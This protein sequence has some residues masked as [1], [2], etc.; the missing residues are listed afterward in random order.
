MDLPG[1]QYQQLPGKRLLPLSP[2][3]KGANER[4]VGFDLTTGGTSTAT[5]T[6]GG[7]AIIDA[8]VTNTPIFIRT[9]QPSNGRL[10][11]SIVINNA[12]LTN[13]PVA[14]GVA[15]GAVVL[16]GGTTTIQ[17]WGQGNVFTGTNPNG[18]FVQSNIV[19]AN[20]PA[21]LLDGSGKIFGKSHPQYQA[22][23][24]SQIV[25]VKD[26]GARGDG[27]T[28]DT[29]ALKAIFAK[30]S[31][32][33]LLTSHQ[34]SML[35]DTNSLL[36]VKSSF[37]TQEPTSCLRPSP[38][39]QEHKSLVKLGRSSP[40]KVLPSRIKPVPRLLSKLALL[41]PKEWWRLLTC[42]FRRLALVRSLSKSL[43]FKFP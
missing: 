20:K 14:V 17:S 26:N 41:A 34:G 12:K 4:Q 31:D 1:C 13:V 37:S 3:L 36:D 27:R 38:F 43:S 21:A 11:G 19:N 28:D 15:N 16:A 24:V 25:S 35:T 22:Y 32:Q 5:Q 29:A 2:V 8:T 39:P 18:R 30:V 10:A 7:E 23:A 42:C 40:E 6:T 33:G 9:S